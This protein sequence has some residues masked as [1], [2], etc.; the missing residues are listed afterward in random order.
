MTHSKLIQNA[1]LVTSINKFY[2]SWS[3]HDFVGHKF[4]DGRSYYVDGGLSYQRTVGN[5]ELLD[6]VSVED[7]TLFDTDPIEKIRDK[8][9][10]L[11][12]H[13]EGEKSYSRIKDFS[14]KNLKKIS[15]VL[16]KQ[17]SFHP[18]VKEVVDYWLDH[19]EKPQTLSYGPNLFIGFDS[20]DYKNDNYRG[21][22]FFKSIPLV[23]VWKNH[24]YSDAKHKNI[25]EKWEVNR[26]SLAL[27]FN[28][29]DDAPRFDSPMEILEYCENWTKSN[30]E[31]KV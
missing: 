25:S 9:V 13:L 23:R 28:F 18:I 3:T 5:F 30:L 22:V 21:T 24:A 7:Y 26:D 10:F 6:D 12:F 11:N 14:T 4:S 8:L 29:P 15:K 27:K 20:M 31:G 17:T 1:F 2:C 16:D 19:R